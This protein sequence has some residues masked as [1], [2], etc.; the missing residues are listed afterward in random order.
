M[1]TESE[2]PSTPEASRNRR[3]WL[4]TG[5]VIWGLVGIALVTTWQASRRQR[6]AAE[7]NEKAQRDLATRDSNSPTIRLP[8][9]RPGVEGQVIN[10]SELLAQGDSADDG[11]LWSLEGL[12]DFS[13]TNCDGNTITKADLLGR[14]WAICFVFTKCLGP[15][16]R[17]TAQLKE[18]QDR[19]KTYDIRLV[20]LTVDPARDTPEVLKNY[21]KL[22]GADLSRW[23]FLSGDEVATYG[24]IERG[25]RMP[26]REVTG[27]NR[28]EG[29]EIIHSTNVM[30]VDKD[31]VVQGKFNAS[32]DSE[33]VALRR[34]L[35]KLAVRMPESN[36][37]GLD[38]EP[39]VAD[40]GSGR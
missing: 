21:A 5:A 7:Q 12:E 3:P 36:S 20:T 35:Q 25:F 15:C 14:P 16:P 31:G 23:Y 8:L 13:F 39:P 19:L 38:S 1:S 26:V 27:P 37:S 6:L 32:I 33:M 40:A 9:N 4:W 34:E 22:N 30:L 2:T 29:F 11:P 28:Q 10:I 17:V 24:L 18:L